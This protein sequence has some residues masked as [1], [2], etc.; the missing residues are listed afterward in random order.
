MDVTYTP[1]LA[2]FIILNSRLTGFSAK[3]G[4]F[5]RDTSLILPVYLGVFSDQTSCEEA[6]YSAPNPF[7]TMT[8]DV[9]TGTTVT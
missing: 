2:H 8:V 6:V 1:N 3:F 5:S 4:E 9:H 7:T